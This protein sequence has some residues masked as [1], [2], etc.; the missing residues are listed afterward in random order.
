MY[1][2]SMM[3]IHKQ[4]GRENKIKMDSYK[5]HVHFTQFNSSYMIRNLF[6]QLRS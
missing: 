3:N 6:E 2:E 5:M 4:N 1:N